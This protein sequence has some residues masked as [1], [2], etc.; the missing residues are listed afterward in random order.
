M[1]FLQNEN[2]IGNPTNYY[3]A[4]GLINVLLYKQEELRMNTFTK[5]GIAIV[6]LSLCFS[7]SAQE[8]SIEKCQRL[9]DHIEYYDGLRRKGGSAQQM[10]SWKRSRAD[11]EDDF[12][13]YHCRKYGKKLH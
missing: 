9:K 2:H 10:E 1:C 12:R 13:E 8:V 7:V 3:E 6:F 4:K 5:V 11:V